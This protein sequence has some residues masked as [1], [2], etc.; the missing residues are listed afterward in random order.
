MPLGAG[1]RMGFSWGRAAKGCLVEVRPAEGRAEFSGGSGGHLGHLGGGH[2]GDTWL[3]GPRVVAGLGGRGRR[4]GAQH[5]WSRVGV[6]SFCR[7]HW[8]VPA[9]GMGR[10]GGAKC[11]AG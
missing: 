11:S 10:I 6:V 1:S 8:C 5:G 3:A 9:P 7:V 2:G 4:P